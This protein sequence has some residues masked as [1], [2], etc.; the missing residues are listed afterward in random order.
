MNSRTLLLGEEKL[1][2]LLPRMAIPTI[3]AQLINIIYNIV[4]R[5]YIGQ[6][7]NAT[8]FTA[9]GVTLPIIIFVTACSLLVAGGG[10]PRAAISLGKQREDKASLIVG[11][12]I[13]TT[14]IVGAIVS[15]LLLIFNK[16][17]L[18]LI[19]AT[20]DTIEYAMEYMSIYAV[21][22]VFVMLTV[23]LTYFIT[24]QGNSVQS[25]IVVFTGA[26][27][28]VIIDPVFITQFDMGVK[29]AALATVVSQ[30][31]STILALVFLLGKRTSV[32]LK[33]TDFI[34]RPKVVFPALALG[35]SPFVMQATEAM[36]F[37]CFNIQLKKFGGNVAIGTMTILSAV[38]LLNSLPI[39]GLVQGAQ[40]ILSYNFGAKNNDRV[41]KAFLMVFTISV[42]YSAFLWLIVMI[43][44]NIFSAVF[45]SG[46]DPLAG[47]IKELCNTA[48]RI[49][50]GASL[51]LG[52]QSACQQTFVAMGK[53]RIS[54]CLSVLRKLVLLLPLVFIMPAVLN[55]S[56]EMQT[57]AV[58][59]AE[60]IADVVAVSTTLT[61]FALTFNKILRKNVA[62]ENTDATASAEITATVET[63]E[64]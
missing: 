6:L 19:G 60:P 59:W 8:A 52:A 22:V 41:K 4:D 57:M 30:C 16:E 32:K 38:M 44:P 29:G 47:Q 36:I 51:L 11:N 13:T 31:F 21:G 2:K 49:Y 54:I 40:P 28:N 24:A 18:Y 46:S 26:V 34:P 17:I 55:E 56:L 48:L 10:A 53:I 9:V 27:L 63:S 15:A 50:M 39:A 5:I 1:S 58:F 23:G 12:C 43:A 7:V 61:V 42:A 14:V 35:F 62:K 45:V 20:E 33:I 25:L 3:A 64:N 37:L